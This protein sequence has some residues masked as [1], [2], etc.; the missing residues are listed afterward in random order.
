MKR[1]GILRD[2]LGF[3]CLAMFWD[4]LSS[5]EAQQNAQQSARKLWDAEML[6]GAPWVLGHPVLR[7]EEEFWDAH[8]LRDVL[9]STAGALRGLLGALRRFRH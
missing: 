4:M 7:R 2:T 9:G 1:C 3:E 6:R 5:S 8:R